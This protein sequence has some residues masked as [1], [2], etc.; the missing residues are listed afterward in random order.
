M[1]TLPDGLGSAQDIKKRFSVAAE[2]REQWRSILA[3][4]YD[5]CIPNRE[6][7]NFHSAG[8][9]KARHLFDSTAPESLQTFVSVVTS[10][11][12]P[13]HME[14]M[15]Y[16]AGS[17]VPESDKKK[18]NSLLEDATKTFF[19]HLSHSDFSSQ[20]NLSHQDMAISTGA[21]IVEEGDD[22]TEPL[23]K[24]TAVPLSELYCE[25]TSMPRV[26]TF[27]RKH[28][29]KAQEVEIK[30]PGAEISEK[31]RHRIN[32][33]PT[34]D[35][36]IIDGCQV[37][38]FKD[39]TYHQ[40]VIWDDEVIFHQSYADSPPGIVYRFSKIAGET[41]GRGPADMA[42]ADIRTINVVKEYL[43]KNA[44]LTLSPPMIGA[45]DGVF[46]PHTA[47]IHP[48]VVMAAQSTERPPLVPLQVGGDLRVGQFVIEDLQESIRKS[49]FADP[50]G[51]IT[52]PVRSATENLIRQ[53]EMLK[54]RGA[55]FTRL[56]SE[57]VHPFVKRCTD[58]L[59]S[60]GK[61]A[62][63]K[64]DGRTVSLKMASPL[65]D[66]QKSDQVDNLFVFLSAMQSIPQEV[67]MLGANLESVP[68]FLQENLNLPEGLAKTPEQ[69]REAQQQIMQMAQ[70]QE[71]GQIG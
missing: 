5:F 71:G 13:D 43:L 66:I 59:V 23:L 29:I 35:V 12:T 63:I 41:Y 48:G 17:D 6:T 25:P 19:K 28:C 68:Q 62:P 70:Q 57:F 58:I 52:D 27:F 60:S 65:A 33:A 36:D 3:D 18:V 51:D 26:H 4:M 64:V 31:L 45:S 21:L 32:N 9:R 16:E 22:I 14:W 2:R 56:F 47:R 44:A 7:F 42:M 55:N 8:Q 49:F 37:F 24:I 54:K 53:Q 39:K 40:V 38:N 34:S 67:A 10:A 61:I 11:M 69:I 20:V 1:I 50:L 30:F 46:N 15:K